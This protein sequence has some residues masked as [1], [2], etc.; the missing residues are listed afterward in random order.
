M[1][2]R[3]ERKK[4]TRVEIE[5]KEKGEERRYVKEDKRRRKGRV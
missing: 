4:I 1:K 5:G 2:R 3:A